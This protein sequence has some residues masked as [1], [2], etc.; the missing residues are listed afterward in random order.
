[1]LELYV[2]GRSC[3]SKDALTAMVV[4]KSNELP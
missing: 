4:E 3:L 2:Q 1:M